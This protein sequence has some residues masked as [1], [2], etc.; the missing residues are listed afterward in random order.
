M[1]ISLNIILK[2]NKM[3]L[4]DFIKKNKLTSY[5]SLVEYCQGR[6]FVPC[7]EEDFKKALG[8]K[9]KVNVI[10]KKP[11]RTTSKTQ[12]PKKRR[13]RRKKQQDTPKLPDGS[14]NG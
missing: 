14:D 2:K 13:N 12:E 9:E 7:S 11:S 10:K 3:C 6:S 8:I 4:E 5:I 1:T